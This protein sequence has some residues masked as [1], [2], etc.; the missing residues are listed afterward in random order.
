MRPSCRPCRPRA[1]S[2]RRGLILLAVLGC[3]CGPGFPGYEQLYPDEEETARPGEPWQ[4]DESV[5]V[6][7]EGEERVVQ[8]AGL[9]V[10]DLEGAPA[11]PL[12]AVV[13][14]AGFDVALEACRF[15][16][17]ATDGYNLLRKRDGDVDKLPGWAELR[18]G[19]LYRHP[20]GDLRVTWDRERQPWGSA[21]SAYLIKW[22]NG[23]LLTI[24]P[25]APGNEV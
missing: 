24:L 11:V 10:V 22:M 13:Q 25:P 23:G 3:G 7:L 1:G 2:A 18:L 19:V 8:L 16:L 5:R 17:T 6:A 15:D 14:T 21:L 9:A 20:D 4:G 12:V